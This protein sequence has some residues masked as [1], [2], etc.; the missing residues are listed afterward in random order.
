MWFMTTEKL[1]GTIRCNNGFYLILHSY[2]SPPTVKA[3]EKQ[4][5][6]N[7]ITRKLSFR[8]PL[9]ALHRRNTP[10]KMFSLS[11]HITIKALNLSFIIW[12]T[13]EIAFFFGKKCCGILKSQYKL[14]VSKNINKIPWG[15]YIVTDCATQI[16]GR[17]DL[18][19]RRITMQWEIPMF[20]DPCA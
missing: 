15:T 6:H 7:K 16:L 14:C 11:F 13:N 18:V 19:I 4:L 9:K 12:F 20:D 3:S 8:F 17:M 2:H 5:L 10:A 1:P